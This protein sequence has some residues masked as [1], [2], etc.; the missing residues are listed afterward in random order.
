MYIHIFSNEFA[1]LCCKN[2]VDIELLAM[3]NCLGKIFRNQ[4]RLY[5]FFLWSDT[6][7]PKKGPDLLLNEWLS[8]TGGRAVTVCRQYWA[9]RQESSRDRNYAQA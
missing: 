6:S 7:C 3:E 1:S 5:L 2:N 4:G 9:S 8:W